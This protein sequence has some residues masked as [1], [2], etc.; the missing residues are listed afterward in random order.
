MATVYT[1]NTDNL[2]TGNSVEVHSPTCQHLA[3]YK[4]HPFFEEGWI[5][6]VSSPQE[7]FNEYN[8][9]FMN[10]YDPDEDMNPCWPIMIYP[11]SGLV[12]RKTE[13]TEWREI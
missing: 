6:E 5:E 1:L 8:A 2:H 3:K 7:I 12:K 4:S 10:D 13:V 11:C 9:D